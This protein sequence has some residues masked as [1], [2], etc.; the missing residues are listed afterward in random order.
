MELIAAFSILQGL[1]LALAAGILPTLLEILSNKTLL[2]QPVSLSRVFFTHVWT[3][4]S[5]GVDKNTGS[6][7]VELITSNAKGRV[8]DVGAGFGHTLNYLDREQVTT[9]IAIEP[10]L[11]MHARLRDAAYRHN[12]HEEDGT[13]IILS[14]GAEESSKI[15]AAL[16]DND[17][18]DTII[19]VMTLC[20]VPEPEKTIRKLS[21]NVLKPGGQFLFFEH[22]L[23]GRKDIAWWQKF[24]TPIWAVCFDGCKLDRPTHLY[25]RHL[26]EEDDEGQGSSVWS[27]GTTWQKKDEPTDQLFQHY[28]G[29]F[30]R[31][32]MEKKS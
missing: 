23:S 8:L 7:K 18:V 4:F 11:L 32:T 16:P 20:T 10:N 12:F 1:Y 25:V 13:L 6:S 3:V 28:A 15:L 9:Y 22:V 17:G 31:K 27:E 26:V 29:R 2:L 21:L 30:V 24:W 14:C 19:S 5:E